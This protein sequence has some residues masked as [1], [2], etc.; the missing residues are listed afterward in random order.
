ME[1]SSEDSR[2]SNKN[3]ASLLENGGKHLYRASL[4]HGWSLSYPA[5]PKSK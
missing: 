4:A 5:K 3:P 2:L 1:V